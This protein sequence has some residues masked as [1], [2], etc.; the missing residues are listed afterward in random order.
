MIPKSN[1]DMKE[2]MGTTK[3]ATSRAPTRRIGVT[4][5]KSEIRGSFSSFS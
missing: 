1:P 2:G 3:M 5:A 4:E